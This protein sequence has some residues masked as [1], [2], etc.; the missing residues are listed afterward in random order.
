MTRRGLGRGLSALI[1]TIEEPS[2]S[3]LNAVIEMSLE[4]IIPNKNQPRNRFDEES[5]AELAESI[6][7]FGV[8]Q[9]IVVRKLD[10][11]EKYEI[12]TGERRYRATKKVGISTIPSIVVK[13]V[14]DISSLEMALIENI[15]RDNLSPME[16]ANTYKQ[17]IDEFKITHDKLSKRIGKSRVSITNS[18]RLLTLPVEIQKLINEGKISEGHARPIL[19][20]GEEK[21]KI[22]LANLIIK[23]DLSVRE[24]E[25]FAGRKKEQ[26]GEAETKKILQFSKLP[27]ISRKLSEF[28]NAPVKIIQSKKKGK[29]IIEFGSVKDLERIVGKIVQ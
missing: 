26:E 23:N 7:E 14:D 16:K 5:L 13:D 2:E 15:H 24:A 25:K 11:V 28:F 22:K 8:I 10:G 6:K 19:A 12:V 17:L 29:V 1:P 4:K 18:L 3:G 21:E 9:P 20:L 27:E